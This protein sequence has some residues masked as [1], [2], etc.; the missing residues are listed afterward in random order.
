[1]L[2]N[3]D[4]V[5]PVMP[6][7]F[8]PTLGPVHPSSPLPELFAAVAGVADSGEFLPYD[9]DRRWS[10]TKAERLLVGAVRHDERS[11]L[12]PTL[13]HRGRGAV[14]VY[15]YGAEPGVLSDATALARKLAD[16]HEAGAA[17]VVWFLGPDEPEQSAAAVGTRVQLKDFAGPGPEATGAVEGTLPLTP[18]WSDAAASSGQIFHFTAS[19][20]DA[21]H[22]VE[23]VG[24][25]HVLAIVTSVEESAS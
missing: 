21:H 17:R 20:G 6:V 14:K 1:M 19:Q 7:P 22:I 18:Q 5:H 11:T 25:D 24:T 8:V 16:A 13:S 2:L 15:V 4:W 3:W 12:L 10:R 9:K 23:Q